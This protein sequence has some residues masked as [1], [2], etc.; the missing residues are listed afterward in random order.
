MSNLYTGSDKNVDF[1]LKNNIMRLATEIEFAKG[2]ACAALAMYCN[3]YNVQCNV[4]LQR[5]QCIAIAM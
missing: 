4:N 2:F 3:F 1:A 5:V